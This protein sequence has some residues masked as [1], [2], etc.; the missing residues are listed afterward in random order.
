ME[1]QEIFAANRWM[2]LMQ[3][4]LTETEM[5]VGAKQILTAYFESTATAMINR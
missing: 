1:E 3:N 2:Q 4:A 5:P